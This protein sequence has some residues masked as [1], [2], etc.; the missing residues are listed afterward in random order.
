M[1]LEETTLRLLKDSLQQLDSGFAA[2][3][4]VTENPRHPRQTRASPP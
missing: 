3:P 4:A 1:H 2:L